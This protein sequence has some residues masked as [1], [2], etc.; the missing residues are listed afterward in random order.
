MGK[1]YWL[2]L[3]GEISG[4]YSN[5]QIR[6]FAEQGKIGS[7]HEISLDKEKWFRA[8]SVKNLNVVSRPLKQGN[9]ST[10]QEIDQKREFLSDGTSSSP[11]QAKIKECP[12]CGEEILAKAR[13]CKH[14][15]E[16]FDQTLSDKKKGSRAD[17]GPEKTLSAAHPSFLFYIP[18]IVIGI[19]LILLFGLG[20]VIIIL[21]ILDQKNRVFTITNHKVMV[22]WGI[23]SHNT[24]EVAIR[25]IRNINMSQGI[26]A[27]I[28]GF[29]T[30]SIASAGTGTVDVTF[31]GTNNPIMVRDLIR[32]I[33]EESESHSRE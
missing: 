28:F 33:K 2:K 18:T 14:C 32:Q 26:L 30:V 25:D 27:R 21:A 15:G 3:G 12:Y 20:I 4:P 29:G 17:S 8:T 13:K 24:K 6:E 23:I 7:E 16:F 5:S 19:G 11:V 9:A 10:Q 1:Q 31:N 22:K